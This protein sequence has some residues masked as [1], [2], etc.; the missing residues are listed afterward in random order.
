MS[1][2]LD[3]STA[4]YNLDL[5]GVVADSDQFLCHFWFDPTNPNAALQYIWATASAATAYVRLQTNNKLAVLLED[6]VGTTVAFLE[7][8]NAFTSSTGYTAVDIVVDRAQG[9]ARM[10]LDGVLDDSYTPAGIDIDH[11]ANDYAVGSRAGGSNP[12][13]GQIDQFAIWTG[14]SSTYVS[15][16]GE[17]TGEYFRKI[18]DT[19]QAGALYRKTTSI[20]AAL[21]TQPIILLENDY[22]TWAGNNGSTS[23]FPLTIGTLQPE[24][25]G[26]EVP[27]GQWTFTG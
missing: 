23:D 20:S 4:V 27:V 25:T 17:L 7:S 12:F 1:V 2:Y 6:S 22:A 5:V 15:S 14:F 16:T 9:F 26:R 18:Y 21:G 10:Y 11:S 3:G 13:T 24:L 19:D 8:T